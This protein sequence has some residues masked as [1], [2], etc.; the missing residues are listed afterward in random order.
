MYDHATTRAER[1]TVMQRVREYYRDIEPTRRAATTP[2]ASGL[3]RGEAAAR[4]P[5]R[6]RPRFN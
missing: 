5:R 3:T 4:Y 6:R 2:P 1:L